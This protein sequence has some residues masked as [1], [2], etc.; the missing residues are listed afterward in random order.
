MHNISI[1][2]E[3]LTETTTE[4]PAETTTE[5]PTETTNSDIERWDTYC[6]LEGYFSKQLQ[7]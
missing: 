7:K 5:K 2:A 6:R 4:K 1:L 3:K